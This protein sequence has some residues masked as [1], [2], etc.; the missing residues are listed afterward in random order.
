ME[1]KDLT[2]EQREKV[3][4]AKTPE[5]I[6]AMAQQDGYELSDEELDQISGGQA[7]YEETWVTCI[8]CGHSWLK[9]LPDKGTIT[10]KC[11]NCG[12]SM[13]IILT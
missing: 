1:F 3:A 7:W 12:A 6:L 9:N 8:T 10:V 13:D 4:S 11:P 5:E 2:P